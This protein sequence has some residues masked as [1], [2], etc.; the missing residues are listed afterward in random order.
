MV[1]SAA[2]TNFVSR[3]IS[4]DL[5]DPCREPRIASSRRTGSY[6]ATASIA[7]DR[8][9]TTTGFAEA[10]TTGGRSEELTNLMRRILLTPTVPV[11]GVR[12][13]GRCRRGVVAEVPRIGQWFAFGIGG[14]SAGE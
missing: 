7:E 14:A 8:L 12:W 13:V 11:V 6:G 1:F 3:I 9:V 4:R 5:H 2:G 10:E